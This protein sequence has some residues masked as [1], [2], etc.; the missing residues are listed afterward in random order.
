MHSLG[1]WHANCELRVHSRPSAF[2]QERPNALQHPSQHESLCAVALSCL[3]TGNL[4]LRVHSIGLML[5]TGACTPLWILC[6]QQR[7]G[8]ERML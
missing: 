2:L 3:A 6:S 8:M 5:R 1:K 4:R 7:A